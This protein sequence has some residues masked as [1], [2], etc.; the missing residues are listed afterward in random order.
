MT[1]KEFLKLRQKMY[2]AVGVVGHEAELAKD[3]TLEGGALDYAYRRG[4][5]MLD[6]I[7]QLGYDLGILDRETNDVIDKRVKK[8]S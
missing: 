7:D 8:V 6:A 3:G 2:K 5:E 4:S 1:R